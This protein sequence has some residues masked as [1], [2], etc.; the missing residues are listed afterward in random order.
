MRR[1]DDAAAL[2]EFGE[3][4]RRCVDAK[5]GMQKQDRATTTVMSALV[6]GL[7]GHAIHDHGR[8]RVRHAKSLLGLSFWPRFPLHEGGGCFKIMLQCAFERKEHGNEYGRE[9]WRI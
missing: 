1:R 5:A 4:R 8:D 2:G 3:H 9:T 6:D 7:D